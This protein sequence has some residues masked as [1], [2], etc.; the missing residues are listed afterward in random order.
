MAEAAVFESAVGVAIDAVAVA[1]Q[2]LNSAPVA[3]VQSSRMK[4]AK[5]GPDRLA[6]R[7]ATPLAALRW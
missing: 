1:R 6:T 4:G 5:M 7:A 3:A 2:R